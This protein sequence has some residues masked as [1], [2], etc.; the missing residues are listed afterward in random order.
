MKTKKTNSS[1]YSEQANVVPMKVTDKLSEQTTMKKTEPSLPKH[2]L[3]MKSIP[4][5]LEAIDLRDF[6]RIK[7]PQLEPLLGEWLLPQG[8]VMI[9]GP[10]GKGKTHLAFG[11]GCAV[12]SGQNFLGW[13]CSTP[14]K[15]VYL[16]GEMSARM[17]QSRVKKLPKRMRP[18]SGYFKLVTPDFQQGL[19]PDLSSREEHENINAA[20]ADDVDLIIVDNLSCWSKS[21][22][23]DA[24][25][26]AP[27]A[28]W[29]L[30]HRT[31]GRTVI[32][33]HHSGK[34]GTQRGTSRR[35]DLLDVV[36]GLKSP[37]NASPADGAY[38]EIHFEKNRHLVGADVNP[39]SA[40]LV[41]NAE[42][43]HHWVWD[44]V[45][46]NTNERMAK[47]NKLKAKGMN[48]S[49]IAQELRVNRSTVSRDLKAQ[50]A[51]E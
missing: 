24:D 16:D 39:I 43:K 30:A 31:A 4:L 6:V 25:T 2:F 13:N 27:I 40:R 51:K 33:V 3:K 20:I 35:E 12:A 7:I 44:K 28:E 18:K 37:P 36:L 19:L 38:F 49:E 42:G 41:P 8:L 32:F 5:P 22:R 10:R 1:T 23:E 45:N 14:K 48:Q 17:L 34:A 26:W 29:A 21:G 46:R 47:I 9:H 11:I 15:V 50:E